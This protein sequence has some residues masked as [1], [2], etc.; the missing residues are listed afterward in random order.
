[1]EQPTGP[2]GDV[3]VIDGNNAIGNAKINGSETVVMSW[4]AS[5]FNS[6]ATFTMSQMQGVNYKP[7]SEQG[8][9]GYGGGSLF[10]KE[11]NF[12]LCAPEFVT[13]QGNYVN[14]DWDATP[15]AIMS[16]VVTKY[17]PAIRPFTCPDSTI[18][19]RKMIAQYEHPLKFLNRVIDESISSHPSSLY[20]LYSTRTNDSEQYVYETYENAM[21][22]SSGVRLK[23]DNALKILAATYEEKKNALHWIEADDGFYRPSRVQNKPYVVTYNMDTGNVIAETGTNI[24]KIFKVL[25][26]YIYDTSPEPTTGVPIF[27]YVS[28]QNNSQEDM[29]LAQAK[30]KR[31]AYQSHLI[32]DK[33]TWQCIGNPNIRIGSTVNLSIPDMVEGNE[34]QETQISADVLVTAI[35]HK[36]RSLN[37]TPR[38]LMVCSGIK[39]AYA[40]QSTQSG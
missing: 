12:K 22:R 33:I 8:I 38:Y 29:D 36:I 13:C 5:D 15:S 10:H 4:T 31:M 21:T 7:G 35:N 32:Q 14:N 37:M 9:D 16:D 2:F 3:T 39:A 17:F 18:N 1:M 40:T 26:Q 6:T 19:K 28:P 34:S 20:V 27:L 11:Y 23:M 25:G 24:G 30:K